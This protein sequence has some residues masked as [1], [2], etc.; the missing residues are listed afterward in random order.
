MMIM[1][2][3]G[4]SATNSNNV[5]RLVLNGKSLIAYM[6]DGSNHSIGRYE[7][8]DMASYAFID[9]LGRLNTGSKCKK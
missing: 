4:K 5:S 1:H 6:V 9:I 7:S 2:H 3:D 8:E